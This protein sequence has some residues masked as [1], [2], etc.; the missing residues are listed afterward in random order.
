MAIRG[1]GVKLPILFILKGELGG[2]IDMKELATYTKGHFYTV[3]TN[4]WMDN[5]GW[6]FYVKDL[7]QYE[8]SEP[9]VILLDNFDSHV[10]DEGVDLVARVTN[11]LVCPLPAN[12][13]SVCQPLDVGVM[14]PLKSKLRALW[15]AEPKPAKTAAAKRR[16]MIMRTIAAWD[17]ITEDTVA[18]SFEKALTI[19]GC[20]IQV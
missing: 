5:V 1:D 15:L 7:L 18:K 17:E 16:A 4:A 3:Q 19:D 10:S 9:S 13:T 14:G 2:S 20:E 11:S 12:A 8:I 6:E